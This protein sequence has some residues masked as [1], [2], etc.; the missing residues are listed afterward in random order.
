M[1]SKFYTVLRQGVKRLTIV[2]DSTRLVCL[3]PNGEKVPFFLVN[4]FPNFVDVVRLLGPQQ[5]VF[6]LVADESIK[7]AKG[8][9]ISR[10]ASA[11]VDTILTRQPT[12]PFIL[13]GCSASGVVAYEVA[14]Q[15]LARGHEVALLILFDIG[16]PYFL[17]E[18]SII[19]QSF[20]YHRAALSLL[21][22][23][24]IL[25]YL[26]EKA[27]SSA[28]KIAEELA[29]LIRKRKHRPLNQAGFA[30]FQPRIDAYRR[31]RPSPYPGRVLVFRRRPQ[32]SGRYLDPKL[33][34]GEVVLGKLEVFQLAASEH[35]DIFKSELDRT[36]IARKLA[37]F[38]RQ[39]GS[40]ETAIASLH[41]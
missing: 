33:G 14:Q 18:Y 31:Y 4:S 19:Y 15:L 39:V 21:P 2:S 11:H 3:Q 8:Y 10:E 9:T 27:V 16:N 36:L 26:T 25:N 30:P 22:K 13:G 6:S 1:K 29:G 7:A 28:A 20:I 32:L 41:T 38:F 17:R 23:R 40:V 24:Q 37:Q 12:G 5:P 35:L 34:W